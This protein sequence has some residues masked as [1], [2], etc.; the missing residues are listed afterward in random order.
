MLKQAVTGVYFSAGILLQFLVPVFVIIATPDIFGFL[1][2]I[3]R[4]TEADLRRDYY[5]LMG[6]SCMFAFANMGV[7]IWHIFVKGYRTAIFK[8]E[9][10]Y[11]WLALGNLALAYVLF[12]RAFGRIY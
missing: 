9:Y 8:N 6:F 3:G 7:L 1:K 11:C 5:F 12:S 2:A 10:Y 4:F